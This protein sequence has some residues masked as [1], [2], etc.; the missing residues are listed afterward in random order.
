MSDEDA[1]RQNEEWD[2]LVAFYGEDKVKKDKSGKDWQI[3]ITPS[4]RLHLKD[5]PSD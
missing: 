4:F 5:I 3:E 1:A 2:A